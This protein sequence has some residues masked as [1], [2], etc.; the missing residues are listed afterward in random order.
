MLNKLKYTKMKTLRFKTIILIFAIFAGNILATG[1]TNKRVLSEEY[2]K[3]FHEQYT[4]DHNTK[5]EITNKFGDINIKNWDKDE[6]SIDATITVKSSNKDKADKI[7][8]KIE[9]TISKEGNLV[10]A[11]TK[12]IDKIH[13][14]DFSIDYVV[15]TPSYINIQLYNKFGSV[16]IEELTGK[17]NISVKYG[18]L[19]ADKIYDDNTKPLSKINLGYCNKANITEFNWG[20]I[21]IKYSKIHIEKSKALIIVSK[22]SKVNVDNSSSIV[23]E[24][25]YDSYNLGD[26]QNLV[27]VS[28]YTDVNIDKV[29]KLIDLDS[30][31]GNYRIENIPAEFESVKVLNKYGKINI[32]ISPNASYKLD[33][34]IKYADIRYPEGR[35]SKIKNNNELKVNG[36]IGK[37]ATKSTVKITSQYGDIYLTE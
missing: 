8:N 3:K 34:L 20:E 10:K 1:K 29:D 37:K 31:Y 9:V 4:I 7:F 12:I 24:S 26:V 30:R 27:I 5:F 17:S 33:A 21:F 35:V 11:V 36:K 6:I 18:N 13:N 2:T 15:N 19:K 22:Y 32:G 23:A 14:S 16:Y 25:G 28:K